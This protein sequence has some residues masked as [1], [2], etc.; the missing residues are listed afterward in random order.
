M[1]P[2]TSTV[3]LP[4][5][6]L[7]KETSSLENLIF[8]L[9]DNGKNT[10]VIQVSEKG[11]ILKISS[12]A[13]KIIAGSLNFN[14]IGNKQWIVNESSPLLSKIR[15][16]I[17]EQVN[18]NYLIEPLG[19]RETLKLECKIVPF[20]A[21][22]SALITISLDETGKDAG[23]NQFLKD[24]LDSI[25]A[26][27]AVFDDEHKY[28]YLNK[29]AVNDPEMR[30][31][32]IGR[33]DFDYCRKKGIP[34]EFALRRR[35]LFNAHI[36][37]EKSHQLEPVEIRK[38]G[39]RN[40]KVRQIAPFRQEL[41][42]NYFV[43]YGID[44]TEIQ[45]ER[46]RY[47]DLLNVLNDA[48]VQTDENFRI[49]FYNKAFRELCEPDLDFEQGITLGTF[50][51]PEDLD[52]FHDA[53]SRLNRESGK[54]DESFKLRVKGG[55]GPIWTELKISGRNGGQESLIYDC[56]FRNIQEVETS[57]ATIQHLKTAIENTVEGVGIVNK[58]DEYTYMNKAHVELFG[59]EHENEILGNSWK[60]FY[61]EEEARRIEFEV[62]PE[63]WSKGYYRGPTKGLRKDGSAI[64]QMISLTPLP[65]GALICVTHD[66]SEELRQQ[67]KVNQLALVAQKTNSIVI[68]SDAEARI[69][70]VNKSFEELTGFN[71]AEVRDRWPHEVMSGPETDQAIT[72]EI[73][74]AV[75]AGKSFKGEILSYSKRGE[76]FW[77]YLDITPFRNE[78]GQVTGFVS[79]E[80]N[81]TAIK[82]A[83]ARV[84]K[85]LEKEKQL[86]HLKSQFVNLVSHEFRT[87]LA[88]IQSSMD[89]LKYRSENTDLP[90]G[91]LEAL[92]AKHQNRIE[93]EIVRMTKIM[94]N[95]LILGKLDAG[96][97]SLNWGMLRM[98]E[99][100][101][102]TLN[103]HYITSDDTRQIKLTVTG[104]PRQQSGDVVLLR[105]ILLNLISNALKYSEG[106]PSPEIEIDYSAEIVLVRVIDFGIGVPEPEVPSLFNSFYRASNAANIN[107]TGLGLVIVKQLIELHKGS[108]I[109]KPNN[110][111]GCIFELRL[112][113]D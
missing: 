57:N 20:P 74:E 113:G 96:R 81:I 10:G 8:F 64:H 23:E 109:L 6:P 67:R 43:G 28:V 51:Y 63:L 98:D 78:K 97:M 3:N 12:T 7:D 101:A 18:I 71:I 85:S 108:I 40:W 26:D 75:K 111:K 59:Y 103:E 13:E 106:A 112:P 15:L 11:E 45:E 37:D 4:D 62:F 39:A 2:D 86:N 29:N 9:S 105:H 92:L 58:N 93:Q 94:D 104:A 21:R 48:I 36:A 17:S 32:L 35:A 42:Q 44:V 99:L 84:I 25:P 68:I 5:Q 73:Y 16:S 77:L 34:E 79:V 30:A 82:E 102:Q 31:W 52:L 24:L 90:V 87:P 53:L 46:I 65:D 110:P 33:D 61:T 38:E 89:I 88:T 83:E 72:D 66:I 55:N 27:I 22:S 80:S 95:T 60:M 69:K 76:K 54:F 47:R 14:L 91:E 56:I 19:K 49:R 100:I 1:K 107:G 41:P 70:W 50:I